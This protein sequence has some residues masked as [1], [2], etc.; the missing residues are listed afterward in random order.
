MA[1]NI[2]SAK[3]DVITIYQDNRN[4]WRWQRK[5]TD[6]GKIV[7][8]STESYVNKQDCEDNAKRQF[9]ACIVK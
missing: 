4:E 5:C 7:G 6:N 2:E 1:V 3:K 9:V 8:A